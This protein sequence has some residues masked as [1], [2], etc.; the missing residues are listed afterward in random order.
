MTTEGANQAETEKV[1]GEKSTGGGVW[2]ELLAG[3]GGLV[4]KGALLLIG[5]FLVVYGIMIA[6][7]PRESAFNLPKPPMPVP[8]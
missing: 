8:V 6:V 7:R 4:T 2:A 3:L 1:E 5:A